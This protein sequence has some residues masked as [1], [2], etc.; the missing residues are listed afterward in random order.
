M[1]GSGLLQIGTQTT[2]ATCPSVTATRAVAV[3][4]G[5]NDGTLSRRRICVGAGS[6]VAAAL[7]GCAN[8]ESDETPTPI[9]YDDLEQREVF[10]AEALD[11]A[12]PPSVPTVETRDDADLLLLPGDTAVAAQEAVAWL[13]GDRV[14]ALLGDEAQSTWLAWV[15]SEAYRNAFGGTGGSETDPAPDLLVALPGPELVSTDRTTWGHEYD[16]REVFVALEEALGP[17]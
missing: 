3:A 15:R 17:E 6:L 9:E 14:L 2:T 13:E 16:D 11:I 8:G 10:V 4:S 7:A 1:W 5:M 12:V